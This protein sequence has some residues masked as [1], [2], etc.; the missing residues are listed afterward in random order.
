MQ[1]ASTPMGPEP[2][3]SRTGAVAP[4]APLP[5]PPPP[6]S[7]A[8]SAVVDGGSRSQAPAQSTN[9]S[10]RCGQRESESKRIPTLAGVSVSHIRELS[11]ADRGDSPVT[12]PRG[13]CVSASKTPTGRHTVASTRPGLD[14]DCRLWSPSTGPPGLLASELARRP[15]SLRCSMTSRAVTAHTARDVAA[16]YE[17]LS[18]TPPSPDTVEQCAAAEAARA[19]TISRGWLPA[20][21]WDD[22]DAEAPPQPAAATPPPDDVD[23]IAIERALAGD[24]IRY[25]QLTPAERDQVIHRLTENGRSTRRDQAHRRARPH[26]R[27]PEVTSDNR[28]RRGDGCSQSAE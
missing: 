12:P 19:Q 9:T 4:S 23:E 11:A 14:A 7:P 13:S 15:G 25:I 22:I 2:P 24:G 5:T 17:R 16:L 18:N 28:D 6:A 3:T 8:G 10:Q 21:A 26:N 27:R 20:L 1:R